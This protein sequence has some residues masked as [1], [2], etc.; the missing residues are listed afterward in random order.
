MDLIKYRPSLDKVCVATKRYDDRRVRWGL[1]SF[2][3]GPLLALAS[4]DHEQLTRRSIVMKFSIDRTVDYSG[5][6]AGVGGA[7]RYRGC[8]R[9]RAVCDEVLPTAER[10]NIV[11]DP[12]PQRLKAILQSD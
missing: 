3:G 1:S 12:Q 7:K 9:S 5:L 4:L 10:V 8:H 2:L 11:R 6:E